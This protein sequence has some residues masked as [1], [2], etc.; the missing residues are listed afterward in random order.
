M[1]LGSAVP[2][3]STVWLLREALTVAELIKPLFDTYGAIL[4]K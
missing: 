2:D 3:F 1:H 4:E